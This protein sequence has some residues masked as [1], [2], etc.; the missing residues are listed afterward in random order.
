MHCR[1][2]D[3]GANLTEQKE[4][5]GIEFIYNIRARILFLRW[6]DDYLKI[7]MSQNSGNW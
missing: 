5:S 2:T 7:G 4:D 6:P 3:G 1:L